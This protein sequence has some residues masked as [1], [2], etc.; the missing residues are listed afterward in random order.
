MEAGFDQPVSVHRRPD[1]L[2]PHRRETV[3]GGSQSEEKVRNILP[4]C[5]KESNRLDF[6]MMSPQ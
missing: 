4:F 3:S 6:E 1:N 2:S 5:K